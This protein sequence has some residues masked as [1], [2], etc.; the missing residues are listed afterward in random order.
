MK[1]ILRKSCLIIP[2]CLPSVL[3]FSSCKREVLPT[4]TTKE[5]TEI[6]L[7]TATAGGNVTNDGGAQVTAKGVCWSETTD[8]KATLSTR[9]NDGKGV[10]AFTSYITGLLYGKIYHVRA[11]ATNSVGTAYGDDIQFSTNQITAPSISTLEICAVASETVVIKG[12]VTNDGGGYMV[13]GVCWSTNPN[14]TIE[15]ATYTME[16][17]NIGTYTSILS[18]LTAST[19]YYVR[20]YAAN[21]ADTVYSE[22]DVTFT[23]L[24]KVNDIEGNDYGIVNI[25]TQVWLTENLETATLNDG[26]SISL[27]SDQTEWN[28]L[29]TPGYCWFGNDEGNKQYMGALYNWHAVNT[30]KLCPAG[31]HVPSDAEWTSLITFLGINA[32][33]KLSRDNYS[34]DNSLFFAISCGI[35]DTITGFTEPGGCSGLDYSRWW[36]TTPSRP[37]TAWSRQLSSSSELFR[38]DYSKRFGFS[39]R[40]LKD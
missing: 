40:C 39:V 3:F 37:S 6:S 2:I 15:S 27:V 17:A 21:P 28:N 22:Q 26:K 23:T 31:W 36:S 8:P 20:A 14:P 10:G 34:P 4:V 32:G 13:A 12:N 29:S 38:A 30:G 9:T 1:A 24:P 18:V 19:H 5:V 25:G 7:E 33:S 11:Y 16:T 35:R